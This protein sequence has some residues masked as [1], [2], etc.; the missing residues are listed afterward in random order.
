MRKKITTEEFIEMIKEVHQN[1]YDY[2]L[3]E[4]KGMEVP[5]TVISMVS[6]IRLHTHSYTWKGGCPK[7]DKQI[8]RDTLVRNYC[9]EHSITLIE[10]P[11]N[12]NI[13]NYLKFLKNETQKSN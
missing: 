13:S 2:S 3:V 10:I 8:E 7:Y 5:V 11:Y 12:E 1:E 6:L 9:L 4:Y